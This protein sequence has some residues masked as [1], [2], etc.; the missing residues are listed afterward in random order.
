MLYNS[1]WNGTQ[2]QKPL[3]FQAFLKFILK[4]EYKMNLKMMVQSLNLKGIKS[5]ISIAYKFLDG[6]QG[7]SDCIYLRGFL[8]KNLERHP[9]LR[10]KARFRC[11]KRT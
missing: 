8:K 2:I 11:D 10:H 6:H 3:K 1:W 5:R 4:A 7:G 9:F